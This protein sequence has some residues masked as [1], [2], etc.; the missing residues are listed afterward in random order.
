MLDTTPVGSVT[1]NEASAPTITGHV[2]FSLLGSPGIECDRIP[3]AAVSHGVVVD[4]SEN[5][6][7]YDG[8][9]TVPVA[10]ATLS[11]TST[12][13]DENEGTLTLHIDAPKQQVM[14]G[15][16]VEVDALVVD[17]KFQHASCS[18]GSSWGFWDI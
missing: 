14:N 17:V 3:W 13:D 11:V 8:N 18:G 4:V 12:L 7:A 5:C 2:G 9:E 1:W 15:W 10:N 16:S 6:V